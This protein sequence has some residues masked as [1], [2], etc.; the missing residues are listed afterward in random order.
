M[1]EHGFPNGEEAKEKGK[2]KLKC[3]PFEWGLAGSAVIVREH[4]CVCF[5]WVSNDR[6]AVEESMD[7]IHTGLQLPKSRLVD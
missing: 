5:I 1:F 6:R 3:L 7:K 2:G 4:R